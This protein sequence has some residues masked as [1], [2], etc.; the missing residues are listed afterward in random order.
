MTVV[1]GCT[2][3]V[4]AGVVSYVLTTWGLVRTDAG[5]HAKRAV[6]GVDAEYRELCA[7]ASS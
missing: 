2:A 1:L 7:R 3:A 4:S 6:R 5:R